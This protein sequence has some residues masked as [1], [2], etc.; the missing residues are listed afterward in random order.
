MNN[1]T[2]S[3]ENPKHAD[4]NL[5]TIESDKICASLGAQNIDE[6]YEILQQSP[7]A[8]ELF[9]YKEAQAYEEQLQAKQE[10]YTH[11]SPIVSL[12]KTTPKVIDWNTKYPGGGYEKLSGPQ[13]DIV[14]QISIKNPNAIKNITE[15]AITVETA[16]GRK[17]NI[18]LQDTVHDTLKPVEMPQAHKDAIAKNPNL[19]DRPR[20]SGKQVKAYYAAIGQKV[21]TQMSLQ[22]VTGLMQWGTMSEYTQL[23]WLTQQ[24]HIGYAYIDSDGKIDFDDVG[25]CGYVWVG[26]KGSD[27]RLFRAEFYSRRTYLDSN[28]PNYLYYPRLLTELSS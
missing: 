27:G 25:D 20:V 10:F 16:D 23:M 17:F 21:P 1:T 19:K 18:P 13:K 4:F 8:A 24:D 7:L 22:L 28:L 2:N 11:Q 9:A 15:T 5:D 6:L 26:P 14:D 12:T 3:S